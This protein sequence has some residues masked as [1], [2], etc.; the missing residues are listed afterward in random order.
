MKSTKIQ[1]PQ[2]RL[3]FNSNLRIQ[4]LLNYKR[5][6]KKEFYKKKYIRLKIK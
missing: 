1:K 2:K 4:R 3:G 5:Q 6:K